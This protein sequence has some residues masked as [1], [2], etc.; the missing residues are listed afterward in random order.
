MRR[1]LVEGQADDFVADY[2]VIN[3]VTPDGRR[4][5]SSSSAQ[6]WPGGHV[7]RVRQLKTDLPKQRPLQERSDMRARASLFF[8]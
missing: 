5:A 4:Q 1:V 8:C 2:E 3:D 6:S 7:P